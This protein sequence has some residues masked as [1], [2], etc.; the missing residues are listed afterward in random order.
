MANRCRRI[1]FVGVG[2]RHVLAILVCPDRVG[3]PCVHMTGMQQERTTS[4][5][6]LQRRLRYFIRSHLLTKI[7]RSTRRGYDAVGA[8]LAPMM[9]VSLSMLSTTMMDST[10]RR[11]DSRQGHFYTTVVLDV[12]S[13]LIPYYYYFTKYQSEDML[14]AL[15]LPLI[16]HLGI[17]QVFVLHCS[18]SSIV[19]VPPRKSKLPP[20]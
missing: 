5:G 4:R 14:Y 13:L 10:T 7:L 16:S 3:H 19:C 15:T 17:A 1:R 2:V 11:V 20:T 12:R 6:I 18:P 8:V 9:T